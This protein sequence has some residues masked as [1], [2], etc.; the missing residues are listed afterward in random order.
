MNVLA[1]LHIADLYREPRMRIPTMMDWAKIPRILAGT[2][3]EPVPE[4]IVVRSGD[5]VALDA[6]LA[7]MDS[8]QG[9]YAVIDTEYNRET[10]FLLLLGIGLSNGSNG[11]DLVGCQIEWHHL[12]WWHKQQVARRVKT[13][14]R[15]VPVVFQ[16]LLA[17]MPVLE[18]AMEIVPEEYKRVDDLMLAHAVLW[19]EWPHDLEFLASLY[20]RYPKMKQ[21]RQHEH[22]V[23]LF[24]ECFRARQPVKPPGR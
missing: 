15:G 7:L 3:P 22:T 21:G 19:S 2:W 12:S 16:N 5:A 20:G 18:Q 10:K 8:F 9:S 13:L 17:D 1:T 14:V 23:R 6:A 4:R 24:A 11:S